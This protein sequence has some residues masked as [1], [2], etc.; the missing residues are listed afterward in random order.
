MLF[1]LDISP[2]FFEGTRRLTTSFIGRIEKGD[3]MV[4]STVNVGP[5]TFISYYLVFLTT[6][7]TSFVSYRLSGTRPFFQAYSMVYCIAEHYKNNTMRT[8]RATQSMSGNTLFIRRK[9]LGRGSRRALR[10][11]VS[12]LI[13]L[14]RVAV[15]RRL[16]KTAHKMQA[17]TTSSCALP[18][19]S[20]T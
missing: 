6:V 8:R 14:S 11:V 5:P 16:H 13:Y 7:A 4:S 1:N 18:Q 9:R 3:T 15:A 19:S 17:T 12:V 10:M 2:Q 20:P